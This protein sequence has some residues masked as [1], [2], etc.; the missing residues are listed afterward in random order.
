MDPKI[1]I[2]PPKTIK[3]TKIQYEVSKKDGT[4]LTP[5]DHFWIRTYIMNNHRQEI[6]IKINKINKINRT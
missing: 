5:L 3:S 4:E 6:G 1:D 2:E